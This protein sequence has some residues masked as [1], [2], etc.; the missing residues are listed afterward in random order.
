MAARLVM[1]KGKLG[2]AAPES[3]PAIAAPVVLGFGQA[4]AEDLFGAS[5]HYRSRPIRFA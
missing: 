4:G 2:Q 1:L 5:S 3:A